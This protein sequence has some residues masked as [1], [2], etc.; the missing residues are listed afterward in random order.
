LEEYLCKGL[1]IPDITIN[2]KDF[3]VKEAKK[4]NKNPLL[5]RKAFLE[6]WW[7]NGKTK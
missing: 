5:N 2:V 1:A 6:F 4:T 3:K 7:L